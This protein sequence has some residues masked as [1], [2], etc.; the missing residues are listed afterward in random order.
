M[1]PDYTYMPSY[2]TYDFEQYMASSPEGY[3]S[4]HTDDLQDCS[5]YLSPVLDRSSSYHSMFSHEKRLPRKNH[6]TRA[7]ADRALDNELFDDKDKTVLATLA[8][9]YKNDWKKIAKRMWKLHNKKFGI[10][11]LR[12]QFKELTD[13]DVKKRVRF[14]HPEDLKIAKYSSLYGHD[15]TKIATYFVNRTPI[16][17]KNRYYH[18]K[19]KGI[20]EQILKEVEDFDT[21][22]MNAEVP[23]GDQNEQ[24]AQASS[25]FEENLA[26]KQVM[27][28]NMKLI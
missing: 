23:E 3:L 28:P 15:W 11:F 22:D 18:M 10:N 2:R 9:K 21:Q 20:Y 25:E 4:M 19:K 1:E 5:P 24:K 13:N 12:L 16:M 14:T 7:Y 27:I 26:V 6:K 8:F 17:L